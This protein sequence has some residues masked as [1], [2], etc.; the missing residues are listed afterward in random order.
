MFRKFA[1]KHRFFCLW[2]CLK[3]S[4]FFG[5][6]PRKLKFFDPGPRP[7]RFQTRFTPLFISASRGWLREVLKSNLI[8]YIRLLRTVCDSSFAEFWRISV[9]VIELVCGRPTYGCWRAFQAWSLNLDVNFARF[10]SLMPA[11]LNDQE[12]PF[13]RQQFTLLWT[14][15]S[16]RL[17]RGDIVAYGVLTVLFAS[18][19]RKNE[20]ALDQGCTTR[21]P[22]TCYMRPSQKYKTLLVNLHI[23]TIRNSSDANNIG[24]GPPLPEST[25][26]RGRH[27]HGPPLPNCAIMFGIRTFRPP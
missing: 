5:N 6:F 8:L 13:I 25:T 19:R 2:N 18:V 23:I 7:P 12:G 1:L 9:V 11:G 17:L 22:R 20:K 16:C 21:G 27:S 26:F 24:L 14:E 4:K 10:L 3:E 15:R